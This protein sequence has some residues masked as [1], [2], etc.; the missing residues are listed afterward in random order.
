MLY[1]G[2]CDIQGVGHNVIEH[3]VDFYMSVA[4]GDVVDL[5]AVASMAVVGDGAQKPLKH[6]VKGKK[7]HLFNSKADIQVG[8]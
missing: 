8:V 3:L 4:G 7:I 2:A 6:K 5:I 1:M